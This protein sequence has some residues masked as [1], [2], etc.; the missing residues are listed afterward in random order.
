MPEGKELFYEPRDIF[1]WTYKNYRTTT[2][3]LERGAIGRYIHIYIH[4][5][6]H[7]YIHAYI[8]TYRSKL[9]GS[10]VHWCLFLLTVVAILTIVTNIADR[11]NR[12][13]SLAHC[14]EGSWS[15]AERIITQGCVAV[16]SE[17]WSTLFMS[18]QKGCREQT[19]KQ[20]PAYNPKV[21]LLIANHYPLPCP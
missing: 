12:A 16:N 20:G 13:L 11:N 4:A 15:W 1:L 21:S 18:W 9:Q 7:T 8:H 14:P 6:K 17:N 3:E 5:Y 2:R 10:S 19:W